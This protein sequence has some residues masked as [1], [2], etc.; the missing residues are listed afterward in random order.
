M[1]QGNFL[2]KPPGDQSQDS[3]EAQAVQRTVQALIDESRAK[4][5]H[6]M[7]RKLGKLLPQVGAATS[8]SRAMYDYLP[9]AVRG[10]VTMVTPRR[11]LSELILTTSATLALGRFIDEQRRADL[12]RANSLEPRHTVLL[13][14]APG[15]GKTSL[16]EGLAAE[17]GLPFFVVR[18]DAI[19]GSYLGETATR[20]RNLID[21][22]ASTPCVLFFDDFDAIGIER[23]DLHETGEIKRVVNSLLMQLDS[24]PSYTVVVCATNH[25]E[26]LDR[27]VW[28]RFEMR[29]ELP[30]P[31]KVQL[32]KWFK[33]S[34]K[35]SDERAANRFAAAFA[36]VG[37]SEA[38]QFFLDVRRRLVLSMGRATAASIVEDTLSD[39]E[40]QM[41]SRQRVERSRDGDQSS[42]NKNRTKR[43]NDKN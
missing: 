8:A 22:A 42:H 10:L 27:A 32:A 35:I 9:D 17:L 29:L 13:V 33:D 12:L 15:T 30:I 36:G 14:G 4:Q 31:T 3:P 21:F 40:A 11:Y 19:I 43:N 18:Y 25:P 5:E 1:R 20:L 23:G 38:E 41:T 7:A 28:R 6:S 26:L 2:L 39:R 34:L 37:F 16:A 24:L